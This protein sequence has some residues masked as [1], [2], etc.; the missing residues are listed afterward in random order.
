[1]TKIVCKASYLFTNHLLTALM[2][3]ALNNKATSFP[4]GNIA[5]ILHA[6][7][8]CV[9]QYLGYILLTN[10]ARLKVAVAALQYY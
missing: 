4:A 10:V 9:A 5:W 6:M 8:K 3:Y 2:R 1:M 7:I